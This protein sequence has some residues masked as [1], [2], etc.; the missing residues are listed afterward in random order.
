MP[1]LQPFSPIFTVTSEP[2]AV[3][4][5][6]LTCHPPSQSSPSTAPTIVHP[7]NRTSAPRFLNCSFSFSFYLSLSFLILQ[8]SH[9]LVSSITQF[10]VMAVC[11][12]ITFLI[13]VSH[14]YFLFSALHIL[15]FHLSINKFIIPVPHPYSRPGLTVQVRYPILSLLVFRFSGGSG[16]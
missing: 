11:S 15:L 16:R 10:N 7:I 9:H 2:S 14:P 8:L 3:F 13:H 1:N 12:S 6:P 4:P 5:F